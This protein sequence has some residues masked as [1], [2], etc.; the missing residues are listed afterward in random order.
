MND[1]DSVTDTVKAIH[2]FLQ[3]KFLKNGRKKS[4]FEIIM[5]IFNLGLT[6]HFLILSL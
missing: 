4:K 5:F 2:Y 1:P 3:F 6:K